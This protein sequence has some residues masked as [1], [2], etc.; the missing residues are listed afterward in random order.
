ME[1]LILVAPASSEFWA[2]SLTIWANEG[3][4]TADR[5]CAEVGCGRVNIGR[6]SILFGAAPCMS[7]AGVVQS[8]QVIHALK[9]YTLLNR[10]VNGKVY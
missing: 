7:H 5:I 3:I 2:S 9:I 8:D 4:A 10:P 1:Q 6:F